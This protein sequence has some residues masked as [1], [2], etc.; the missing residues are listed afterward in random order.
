MTI[1]NTVRAACA[2]AFPFTVIVTF[3]LIDRQFQRRFH[4]RRTEFS[5]EVVRYRDEELAEQRTQQ[6]LM[7][8]RPEPV[9]NVSEGIENGRTQH[10]AQI[11]LNRLFNKNR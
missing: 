7:D 1:D 3:E 5:D 10:V 9:V 2:L 4:S 6:S 11:Y 8:Y